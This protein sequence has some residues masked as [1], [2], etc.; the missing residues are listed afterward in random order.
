MK[1]FTIKAN[2]YLSQDIQGYY[3]DDY[4]GYQKQGNP[5]YINHLKNMTKQHDEIEL[6][7]DFI[8]VAD[9]FSRDL[10][11]ILEN[12]DLTNAIICTIPRSKKD[13]CYSQS[14]LMFR[15]A[16]SSIADSENVENGTTAIKR[17]KDTK[18]THNWRLEN[19]TGDDPYVGITKD[20]CEICQNKINGR[21]VVLVDDI[22]TEGVYVAED[23]I[24]TLLNLGAKSVTLYVL[25]KTRS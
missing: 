5:D 11:I 23:C 15:K 7:K 18:T 4:I 9:R 14:Q 1:K 22:Y 8:A 20:T 10:K 12:K 19:N 2:K 17:I 16:I 6:V 24:Q 3:H 25:A 21:N 13:S